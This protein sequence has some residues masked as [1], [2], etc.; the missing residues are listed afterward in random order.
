MKG[1]QIF[2]IYPLLWLKVSLRK[3][4]CKFQSFLCDLLS[5]WKI[6]FFFFLAP[7]QQQL[8]PWKMNRLTH[9]IVGHVHI[10]HFNDYQKKLLYNYNSTHV[11]SN[12]THFT[13]KPDKKK[14]KCEQTL[15]SCKIRCKTSI[16][17]VANF[18]KIVVFIHN[19]SNKKTETLAI[20]L[21]TK[22]ENGFGSVQII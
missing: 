20:H 6:I 2:H 12:V 5:Y 9:F 17:L 13:C 3:I 16:N 14:K 10:Y 21:Y 7:K 15:V 19:M 4:F 22:T 1:T 11:P 18:V 8:F